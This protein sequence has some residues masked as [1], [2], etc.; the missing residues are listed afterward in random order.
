MKY[1]IVQSSNKLKSKWFLIDA[2]NQ[3]LGRLATCITTLLQGKNK[4]FYTP[5]QEFNI[6]IIVINVDKI[7]LTGNKIRQKV[8]FTH[9]GR[10]GGKKIEKFQHLQIRI[11]KRILEHA[12]KGMLPKNRM[13]R[14]LLKK[15]KI[16][17]TNQHQH[18]AQTPQLIKI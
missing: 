2:T 14:K 10:P 5:Y 3:H 16:Y 9:S 11:S 4:T 13:G 7:Y 12:V 18:L 15:L 1:T 8:Y 6:F 17:N